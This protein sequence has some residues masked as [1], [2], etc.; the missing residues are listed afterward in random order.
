MA[1]PEH[2]PRFLMS[3]RPPGEDIYEVLV[4][5]RDSVGVLNS[6]TAVL[7]KNGVNFV[8]SHGQT[9]EPG[10]HFV[11]AFFCEMAKAKCTAD[12]LQKELEELPFVDT[13]LVAKMGGAMYERFM[14]PTSMLYAGKALVVDASAFVM[15]EDRLV[16]MFGTGGSV[17]AYEQG[18]AYAKKLVEGLEVYRSKVG[19][20]WDIENIE[21]S[22]RA[23]GWGIVTVR[24]KEGGFEVRVKSPTVLRG[25]G[26]RAE[27]GRFF[28]GIVV[29]MLEV[30]AKAELN[31]DRADYDPGSQ[32]FVLDV[33]GKK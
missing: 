8:S 31:A 7:K 3:T 12:R 30:Y 15:I 17:M 21:G 26:A 5:G 29:G 22:I 16:E 18:K 32:A 25:G 27:L 33:T 4:A 11:N 24:E 6:I 20:R 2:V 13:V 28:V 14:F 9:D 19:A 1:N 10:T 23:Q